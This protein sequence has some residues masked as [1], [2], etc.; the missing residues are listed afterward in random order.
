MPAVPEPPPVFVDPSGRRRRRVRRLAYGVGLVGLAYTVMVGVSFA[1]GPVSPETVVPFVESTRQ[2]WQPPPPLGTP[3]PTPTVSASNGPVGGG[4]GRPSVRP[5][6]TG[7]SPRSAPATNTQGGASSP[8]PSESTPDP[9]TASPSE[10][11]T[12]E[13]PADGAPEAS[14]SPNG[15]I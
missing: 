4:L 1:G 7:S 9:P 6:T 2:V 8:T 13:P 5:A 12:T 14:G 3:T 15:V 10:P 11:P